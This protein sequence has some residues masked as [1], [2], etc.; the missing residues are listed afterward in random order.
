MAAGLDRFGVLEAAAVSASTSQ[1]AALRQSSACSGSVE[2]LGIRR[3]AL[4][5]SRRASFVSAR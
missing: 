5:D 4:Y 1:W 3:N 2:M